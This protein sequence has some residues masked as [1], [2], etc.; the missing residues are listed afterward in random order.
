MA[1]MGKERVVKRIKKVLEV[2]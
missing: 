1:I 2:L